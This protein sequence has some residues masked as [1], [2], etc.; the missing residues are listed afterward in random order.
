MNWVQIDRLINMYLKTLTKK[1]KIM[2][3]KVILHVKML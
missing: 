3:L 2:I 1:T